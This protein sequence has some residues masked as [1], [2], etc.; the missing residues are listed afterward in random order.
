MTLRGP[1]R[2]V[3]WAHIRKLDGRTVVLE[4][5]VDK[6]ASFKYLLAIVSFTFFL[7]LRYF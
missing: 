5:E 6:D 4:F 3:N 7:P 1:S 2:S